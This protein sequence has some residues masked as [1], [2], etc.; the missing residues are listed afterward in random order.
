MVAA[1]TA[2][3]STATSA[4]AATANSGLPG[5]ACVGNDGG[6]HYSA[7]NHG[8]KTN[9][10]GPD[11]PAYYEV[12]APTGSFAGKTPKG[13]MLVIHGGGWHLVGKA[14]V[15]FERRHADEWRAKGW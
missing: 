13:E 4:H 10:L 12:G 7:P 5:S 15:A 8:E 2:V 14:T 11:A 1:A 6:L 3:A 9:G